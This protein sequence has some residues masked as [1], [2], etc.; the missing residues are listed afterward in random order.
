MELK[1]KFWNPKI[2]YLVLFK[3]HIW[4][5][6]KILKMVWNL[7]EGRCK[8]ID[9]I[10]SIARLWGAAVCATAGTSPCLRTTDVQWNFFL[11][12]SRNFG[13]EQI[14]SGALGVFS[15]KLSVPILALWWVPCPCFPLFSKLFL[16]KSNPLYPHPKH[17]FGIEI[18]K[19]AAKN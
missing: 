2:M 11:L 13:L 18:W 8:N 10:L 15:V 6:Y 19:L 12:K 14:N 1:G 17:L 16:Q 3:G 4:K 9:G 7:G 5:R